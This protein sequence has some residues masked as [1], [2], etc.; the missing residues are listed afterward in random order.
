M[1]IRNDPR[2]RTTGKDNDAQL[3]AA[4]APH[5]QRAT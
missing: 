4:T 5:G 2:Q 3:V 1:T